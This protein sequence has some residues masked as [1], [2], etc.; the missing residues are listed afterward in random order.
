MS[1]PWSRMFSRMFCCC[2]LFPAF[3]NIRACSGGGGQH[4]INGPP[5]PPACPPAGSNPPGGFCVAVWDVNANGVQTPHFDATVTG[6]SSQQAIGGLIPTGSVYSFNFSGGSV[7]YGWPQYCSGCQINVYWNGTDRIGSAKNCS[8]TVNPW[9]MGIEASPVTWP[10]FS[11][12]TST[13]SSAFF[14]NN[15]PSTLTVYVAGFTTSGGMPQLQTYSPQLAL[16]STSS[17]ISVASDGS[18]AT[19]NFPTDAGGNPLPTGHYAFTVANQTSSGVFSI[20]GLSFFSIGSNN[21]TQTTPYGVDLT[22]VTISGQSCYLNDAQGVVCSPFGPGTTP[23]Y[24]I[25][26]SSTGQVNFSQ[27]GTAVNVGS[28]PTAVKAYGSTTVET[29]LDAYGGY[30]DTQEPP[31]AIVTNYGSNTVSILDLVNNAVLNTISVGTQPIAVALNN[32]NPAN[33]TKAY[34]ANYVSLSSFSAV[35]TFSVSG[36]VTSIAASSGQNALVY[37]VYTPSTGNFLAQQAVLSNGS[38]Q[39]DYAQYTVPS[40]LSQE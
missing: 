35:Q 31:N 34:V 20:F 37:T 23:A 9:G 7:Q 14:V 30:Q 4:I 21:T 25:T 22:D 38:H 12:P 6:T 29:T 16:L 28:Q 39:A 5:P 18:S 13:A 32:S 26:L 33:A 3:F 19:F 40:V 17:A 27:N 36:Q 8:P 10:S 11:C 2:L 24:L 1:K 15:L